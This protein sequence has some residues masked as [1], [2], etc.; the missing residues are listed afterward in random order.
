MTVDP[1]PARRLL[2]I[3]YCCD[4]AD[5][6]TAQFVGALGL[7]GVMSTPLEPSDGAVLG[8]H[9]EI[10]SRARFVVDHRGPRVSP[11]IEIQE[12][13]SP[14]VV[15]WPSVDPF[16]VGIKAAGFAVASVADAV[17]R[18]GRSGCVVGTIDEHGAT[19]VDRRGVTLEL[20]HDPTLADGRARLHHLRL[21]V[22]D[23]DVS[24]ALY[25]RLGFEIIDVDAV[26]SAGAVGGPEAADGRRARLR[27]PDEPFEFHLYAWDRPRGFGTHYPVA[28][29]AGIFRLAVAVDDTHA[30]VRRLDGSGW[31]LDRGPMTIA[32]HGTPVA[33]MW[34]A[35]LRDPDG[36]P[37]ELVERPRSAFR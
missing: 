4:D 22:T 8:L 24:L 33:D 14:T 28:N 7:V 18:L 29:H 12:W 2:H 9:G 32:L 25:C 5:A 34:I 1:G 11:S 37:V 17:R 19:M 15:G 6:V 30:A 27:L 21:T 26:T 16:E 3:C 35:F 20:A 10:V 36:I 13:V 23:L 31:R